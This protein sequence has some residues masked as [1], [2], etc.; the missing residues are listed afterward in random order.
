MN[1]ERTVPFTTKELSRT[2]GVSDAYLR[3]L[4]I[5]GKLAGYKQGRDWFIPADVA[6]RWLEERKVKPDKS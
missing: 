1:N 3:Q 6:Q 4:L 2:A 5:A